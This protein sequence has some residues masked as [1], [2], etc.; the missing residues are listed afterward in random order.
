MKRSSPEGP[1][2][3]GERSGKGCKAISE[4]PVEVTISRRQ[5][6]SHK[7]K[8][9][10]IFELKTKRMGGGDKFTPRL[11]RTKHKE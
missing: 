5:T 2:S 9:P 7:R 6:Y 4:L 1:Q 11:Q 3:P 8:T 10:R